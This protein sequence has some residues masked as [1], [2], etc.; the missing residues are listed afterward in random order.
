MQTLYDQYN[1]LFE[2]A[3]RDLTS[4][5]LVCDDLIDDDY[6]HAERAHREARKL[7]TN[8]PE[9]FIHSDYLEASIKRH[10]TALEERDAHDLA[11]SIQSEMMRG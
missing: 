11:C 7:L 8:R 6:S 5:L 2:E 3:V 4:S 1:Q 9:K 10:T